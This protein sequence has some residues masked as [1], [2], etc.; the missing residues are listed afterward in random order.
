[1]HGGQVYSKCW[2]IAGF[3]VGEVYPMDWLGMSGIKSKSR[4]KSRV[5]I[6]PKVSPYHQIE[7]LL[8]R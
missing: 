7:D 4:F 6:C 1:M 2:F 8:S 3:N 5:S